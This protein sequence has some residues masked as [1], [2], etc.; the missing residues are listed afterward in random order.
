M[1]A[2]AHIGAGV[3][4]TVY[5]TVLYISLMISFAYLYARSQ[6]ILID[7]MVPEA[8]ERGERQRAKRMCHDPCFSIRHSEVE[9]QVYTGWVRMI[10]CTLKC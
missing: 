9:C 3:C 1:H 2:V 10:N 8:Q 5:V 4:G 6:S 7:A